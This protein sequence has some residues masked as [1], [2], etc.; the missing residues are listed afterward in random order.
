MEN[1]QHGVDGFAKNHSD[2]VNQLEQTIVH[3]LVHFQQANELRQESHDKMQKKVEL[4]LQTLA[5]HC[6]T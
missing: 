3:N 6:S 5:T 4:D 2:K 1:K